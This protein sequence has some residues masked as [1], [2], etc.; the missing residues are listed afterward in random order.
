MPRPQ[1]SAAQLPAS[2][3][4]FLKLLKKNNDRDWFNAHKERY[5]GELSHIEKFAD[6]LLVEMNSHDVIETASGKKSL[7]RIYRDT[8]FSKDKTPYKNNWSG[9][10]SRAGKQRRGGYYFHIE[11]GNSFAAGGFWAPNPADLKRIRDEFAWDA[12]P[13]RKI[14][15]S[16]AF[17]DSFG[18][19]LGEQIKTTPQGYKADDPAIDLLRYKQFL[20]QRNFSDKEVLSKDFAKELSKTFR[21]MRPFFDYMSVV[22]TTDGDGREM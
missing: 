13:L 15:K 16:K 8:R 9:G 10:F 11:P 18:T 19:L 6:A 14:L 17:R 7:H 12:A 1:S 2:I 22:L 21:A 4:D 20:L 3:L 5:L